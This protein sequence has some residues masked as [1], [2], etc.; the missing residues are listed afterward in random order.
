V[1]WYALSV[2]HG[3]SLAR[4]S[5]IYQPSAAL[6]CRLSAI[7]GL[8]ALSWWWNQRAARPHSRRQNATTCLAALTGGVFFAHTLCLDL[9]RSALQEA[10]LRTSLPWE[11]TV[12]VLFVSTAVI[13]AAFIALVLRTPLR[14]VLGGP[15]RAA[16]R[17][18]DEAPVA[19]TGTGRSLQSRADVRIATRG[20]YVTEAQF[21]DLDDAIVPWADEAA[22]RIEPYLG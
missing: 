15:D 14:W 22:L 7:A 16:Q 2:W 13:T 18:S 4:A 10:G 12:A 6:W 1:L 3:D 11:A 8:F 17:A 9:I 19:T 5:D 21:K 20:L